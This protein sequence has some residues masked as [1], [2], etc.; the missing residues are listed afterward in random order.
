MVSIPVILSLII[1]VH[2]SKAWHGG[3]TEWNQD[4]R[5]KASMVQHAFP[6]TC[7]VHVI[8]H[9]F[10]SALQWYTLSTSGYR[11]NLSDVAAVF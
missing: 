2:L 10:S 11:S 6:Y 3:G 4:P 5:E 8:K 7:T 1:D 9:T